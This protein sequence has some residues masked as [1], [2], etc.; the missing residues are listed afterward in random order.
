MQ[1]LAAGH[2]AY[3]IYIL[4]DG[5]RLLVFILHVGQ[6]RHQRAVAIAAFALFLAPYLVVVHGLFGLVGPCQHRRGGQR[7]YLQRV[8]VDVA[9]VLVVEGR[10]AVNHAAD[11]L[12]HRLAG[13]VQL[14]HLAA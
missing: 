1:T 13:N 10:H 12:R 11:G 9:H 4:V 2:P 5:R 8:L 3:L 14:P 6:L 7:T